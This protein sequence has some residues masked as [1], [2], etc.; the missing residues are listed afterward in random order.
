MGIFRK[1]VSSSIEPPLDN[2]TLQ[3]F[4]P[5][6]G[7]CARVVANEQMCDPRAL[8][9]VRQ[10]GGAPSGVQC[11]CVGDGLRY[12]PGA[13]E[14]GRQCEQDA[15]LRAML[16]SESAVIAVVKPASRTN[17]TLTLIADAHGEAELT[18]AFNVTISR[19]EASSGAVIAANG[20]IRIDQR[21][22]SAFGQHVEWRQ[23]PPAATSFTTVV[24]TSPSA[25]QFGSP[26]S[27]ASRTVNS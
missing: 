12:K 4:Q 15:S 19:F 5:E 13:P 9:E 25:A 26:R 21:S 7:V 2:A 6:G 10:A 1:V 27:Q 18:V 8:C 11:L 24:M 20:S 23:K 3:Y 14:D 22:V 16:G 17:R